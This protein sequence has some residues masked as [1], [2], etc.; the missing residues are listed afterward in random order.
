MIV[1]AKID[2]YKDR[3]TIADENQIGRL[4]EDA[5]AIIQI[6]G[7]KDT[8]LSE[9]E[10][11]VY[12]GVV[13]DMVHNFVAQP[14]ISG[15]ISQ[16]TQTAG[17]FSESYSFNTPPGVLRLTIPQRKL[18]GLNSMKVGAIPSEARDQ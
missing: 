3:Y 16:H 6:E 8:D 13:I 12:R 9:V 1:Y 14:D 17:A 11:S 2:D 15:D 18:L 5:S 4:L 10:V 7:G